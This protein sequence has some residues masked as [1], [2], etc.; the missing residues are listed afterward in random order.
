MKYMTKSSIFY[1]SV[2]ETGEGVD[3]GQIVS[4]DR[5]CNVMCADTQIPMFSFSTLLLG[6]WR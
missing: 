3:G 6:N 2:G 5:K 4:C 1:D